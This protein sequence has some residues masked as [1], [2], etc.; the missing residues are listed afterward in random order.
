MRASGRPQG[1]KL[2]SIPIRLLFNDPDLNFRA[3]YSLSTAIPTTA[4]C[5]QWG[6][7]EGRDDRG[8]EGVSLPSPAACELGRKG[9]CKPYGRLKVRIGDE[10][11]LGSFIFRTRDSTAFEPWRP[12]AVLRANSGNRQSCLPLDTALRRKI[13]RQSH[14]TPIYY[15]DYTVRAG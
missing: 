13:D 1:G 15:V 11:P 10:D 7:G 14:G 2:R 5:W 12:V 6:D 9:G 3:D 4:L 8:D